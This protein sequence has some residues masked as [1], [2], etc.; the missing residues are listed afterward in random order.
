MRSGFS[1]TLAQAH[2]Q[3]QVLVQG[4]LPGTG[5]GGELPGTVRHLDMLVLHEN[6]TLP[7]SDANS[8]SVR[9]G[10]HTRY[11]NVSE[12]SFFLPCRVP[13]T[14]TLPFRCRRLSNSSSHLGS[15]SS[16]N[17]VGARRG[18]RSRRAAPP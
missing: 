14:S 4:H 11:I 7:L 13:V 18:G 3:G 9:R 12:N 5:A 2:A 10:I 17:N 15:S 1:S 8:K 16:N 6:T